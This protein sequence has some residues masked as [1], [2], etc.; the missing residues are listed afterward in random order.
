MTNCPNCGF[1]LVGLGSIDVY[2]C[3]N[4][5]CKHHRDVYAQNQRPEYVP[6][7]YKGYKPVHKDISARNQ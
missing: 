6:L 7:K 2:T 4:F 5:G 1:N 3:T